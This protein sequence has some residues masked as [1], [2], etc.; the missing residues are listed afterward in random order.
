MAKLDSS[1]TSKAPLGRIGHKVQSRFRR[2]IKQRQLP[3]D[4]YDALSALKCRVWYNQY[5]GYCLPED[6]LHRPVARAIMLAGVYEPLTIEFMRAHCGDGDIVHAGM[7]FGDFLPG[8]SEALAPGATVWGFEPNPDNHRCAQITALI[9]R[10]ENAVLVHAGLGDSAGKLP[11][12]VR[13]PEG[14]NL[15]GGSHF[16]EES[17]YHPDTDEWIEIATID[18]SVGDAR[19]VSIIQLD[20]EGH[21]ETALAGALATIQRCRPIL[22]LETRPGQDLAG[23]PWFRDH[24]LALGYRQTG[25]LHRNLVFQIG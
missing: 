15:G 21:E 23:S 16:V 13:K 3:R 18:G 17:E 12:R 5:G 10:L 14:R 4:Q 9:N 11:L 7:F 22:I 6:S 19:P 8:L 2:L 24:I 20:V 25:T 1:T